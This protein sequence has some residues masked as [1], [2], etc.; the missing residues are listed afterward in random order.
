[1]QLK[2]S[3]QKPAQMG[4]PRIIK[5]SSLTPLIHPTFDVLAVHYK[6]T[7]IEET[8]MFRRNIVQNDDSR[9]HKQ[10]WRDEVKVSDKYSAYRND[11][12]EMLTNSSQCRTVVS[13]LSM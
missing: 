3:I 1:M 9:K 11:F 12:I 5:I 2:A 4:D 10:S 8:Q 13:V 6:A 7:E